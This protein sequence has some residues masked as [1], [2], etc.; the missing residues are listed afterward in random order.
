[1][2]LLIVTSIEIGLVGFTNVA[3]LQ[4]GQKILFPILI[5]LAYQYHQAASQHLVDL[6]D[7]KGNPIAKFDQIVF[8]WS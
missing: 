7:F 1:M 4:I 5:I 6:V 3:T 8:F 2:N